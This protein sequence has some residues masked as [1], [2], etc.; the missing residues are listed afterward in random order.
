MSRQI[1][2]NMLTSLYFSSMFFC[3]DDNRLSQNQFLDQ[4][5]GGPLPNIKTCIHNCKQSGRH[6]KYANQ[7][8]NAGKSVASLAKVITQQITDCTMKS[9]TQ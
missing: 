5:Y 3:M 6:D 2:I 1:Y 7:Y 9:I 8:T 4:S